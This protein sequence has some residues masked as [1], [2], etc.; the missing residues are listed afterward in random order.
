MALG[1]PPTL[2]RPAGFRLPDVR[3][4][5]YLED[6]IPDRPSASPAWPAHDSNSSAS[7]QVTT[8]LA[9]KT[10]APARPRAAYYEGADELPA[11]SRQTWYRF[12]ALMHTR[13]ELRRPEWRMLG[14]ITEHA[15][16]GGHIGDVAKMVV[17]YAAYHRIAEGTGWEHWRLVRQLGAV[18]QTRHSAPGQKAS[19]VLTLDPPRVPNDLP[20]E[21]DRLLAGWLDRAV[22]RAEDMA[23]TSRVRYGSCRAEQPLESNPEASPSTRRRVPPPHQSRHQRH[24]IRPS[25]HPNRGIS[26]DERTQAYAVLRRCRPRWAHQRPDIIVDDEL[27]EIVPLLAVVLRWITP[28]DAEEI[29]TERVTSARSLPGL[30]RWRLQRVLRDQRR[31]RNVPVDEDG[32]LYNVR[33]QARAEQLA[34]LHAQTATARTAARAALAEACRTEPVRYDHRS[35]Q[36]SVND[37]EL[38]LAQPR[39]VEPDEEF[40]AVIAANATDQP[41]S[42]ELRH[43]RA[44]RRARQAR[45]TTEPS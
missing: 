6:T 25:H 39:G 24:S 45:A 30:L 43:A 3:C 29:L 10:D 26:N 2:R 35:G 4:P 31:R 18:R 36:Q 44:L 19:Y 7:W 21:L 34:T 20:D 42:A 32:Y 23:G 37:R 16:A 33:A 15:D 14:W 12:W 40:R 5:T 17:T 27:G 22:V 28:H 11:I 38:F 8:G 13:G 1:A 41:T 9:D